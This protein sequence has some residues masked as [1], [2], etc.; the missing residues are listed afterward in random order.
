MP[1][2]EY[3]CEVCGAVFD[4]ISKVGQKETEC[5]KCGSLAVKQFNGESFNFEFKYMDA[6]YHQRENYL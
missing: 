5:R 1:N 6:K 4:K 2:Y 3:K